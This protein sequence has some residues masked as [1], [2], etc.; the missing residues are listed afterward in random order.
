MASR[1]CLKPGCPEVVD[2][3]SGWCD[4][5]DPWKQREAWAGS[6]SKKHRAGRSGWEW[7]R[8]RT[9]VLRRDGHRCVL[10]RKPGDEVDHIVP[11]AECLAAG[12]NPDDM[13]NLRTLCR[14]CHAKKTR[15]DRLR[16]IRRSS[17]E[18]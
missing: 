12:R 6:A 1:F 3:R 5:H 16:G 13:G 18:R 7:R 10:C 14:D 8:L 2:N 9:R 17:R 15:A 4:D 11:V